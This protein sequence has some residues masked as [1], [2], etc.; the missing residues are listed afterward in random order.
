M[1]VKFLLPHTKSDHKIGWM[2]GL[3]VVKHEVYS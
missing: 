1:Y 3:K 2:E